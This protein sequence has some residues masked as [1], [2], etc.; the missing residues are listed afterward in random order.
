MEAG[1]AFEDVEHGV[2]TRERILARNPAARDGNNDRENAEAGA[3]DGDAVVGLTVIFLGAPIERQPARL[4][5]AIPE[6]LKGLALNALKKLVVGEARGAQSPALPILGRAAFGA[7]VD[8]SWP[9]RPSVQERCAASGAFA[10]SPRPRWNCAGARCLPH[11]MQ[12][13]R[14]E[15]VMRFGASDINDAGGAEILQ[16]HIHHA[17]PR[18]LV[19]RFQRFIDEHPIG[20]LQQSACEGNGLLFIAAELV[21]PRPGR[22]R[23]WE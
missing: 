7:L 21:Q 3:A 6:E 22:D 8:G 9:W 18:L 13:A 14:K 17:P 1:R 4:M 19:D 23:A 12:H 20:L 2:E 10:T 15:V 11:D 5:R 16:E